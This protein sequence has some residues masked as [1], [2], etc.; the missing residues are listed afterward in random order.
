[1]ELGPI[2]YMSNF[3]ISLHSCLVSSAFKWDTPGTECVQSDIIAPKYAISSKIAFL[4]LN[5]MR[6]VCIC[7]DGHGSEVLR[8]LEFKQP[9]ASPCPCSAK[10]IV[11]AAAEIG[12]L[13]IPMVVRLQ[14]TN[15][16]AGLEIVS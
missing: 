11:A 5:R 12:S 2:G 13:K 10:A 8:A 7:L 1:M 14:G 6:S 9:N 3:S 4:H 15:S 16:E